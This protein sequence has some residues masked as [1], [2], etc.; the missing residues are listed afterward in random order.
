MIQPACKRIK[1]KYDHNLIIPSSQSIVVMF[2]TSKTTSLTPS[3]VSYQQ[4]QI[5]RG[6]AF[7]IVSLMIERHNTLKYNTLQLHN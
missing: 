6:S 4:Q 2:N 3:V 7:N 5:H 1:S